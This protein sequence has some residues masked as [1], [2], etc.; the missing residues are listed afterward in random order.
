MKVYCDWCGKKFQRDLSRINKHNFCT[1]HH[2]NLAKKVTKKW[3]LD[4]K[5]GVFEI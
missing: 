5:Q 3:R 2:Y 4:I 1:R